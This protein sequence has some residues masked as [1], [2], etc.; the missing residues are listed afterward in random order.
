M[1]NGECIRGESIR[2]V[3]NTLQRGRNETGVIAGGTEILRLGSKAPHTDLVSLS[4][5]G[6]DS[7]KM[8][9]GVVHIG[10]MSTFTSLKN[11]PHIPEYLKEAA[12]FCAS[13]AKANM[14][15]IGGNVANLR[16]DSYLLP[17][18]LAAKARLIIADHSVDGTYSE[19]NIPLREYHEFMDHFAASLILAVELNRKD[20]IVLNRRYAKTAHG[21]A[22]VTVAFGAQIEE[23]TLKEVRIVAAVKGTGIVRLK[24]VEQGIM[25]GRFIEPEDAATIIGNEVA[26]SS[27]VTGSASYKKYILSSTVADLYRRGLVLAEN[28]G[29]A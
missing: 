18:L 13:F 16:D 2:Q 27:D 23:N 29:R 14:A 25:D 17:T 1:Y 6:L 12:G 11:D 3:L 24:G 7:I 20:R 22:A 15:T 4:N 9:N 28:G 19:E 21:N 26:F 10:A 8:E 5:L